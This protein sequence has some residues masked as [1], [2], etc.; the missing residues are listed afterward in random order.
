MNPILENSIIT[1]ILYYSYISF[2]SVCRQGRAKGGGAAYIPH[3]YLLILHILLGEGEG[4]G[5]V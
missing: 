1:A 4:E 2:S 5:A 3:T